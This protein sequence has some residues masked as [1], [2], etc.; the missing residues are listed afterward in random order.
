MIQRERKIKL[1]ETNIF[2]DNR[3]LKR[4]NIFLQHLVIFTD[5]VMTFLNQKEQ[6]K[7]K[8]SQNLVNLQNVD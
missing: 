3:S 4:R 2:E 5:L 1:V 7:R 8:N 6:N